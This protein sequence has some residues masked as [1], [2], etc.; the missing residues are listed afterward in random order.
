MSRR[1]GWISLALIASLSMLAQGT[2]SSEI[3]VSGKPWQLLGQGYQLTADSAVDK[4]GIVYFTD[5]QN[6][7]I[8]K[9]DLE[10]RINVWKKGSHGTHGVAFGANGR[11]YGGQHGRKKIVAF[12]RDGKESVIAEGVQ[13]HHLT[14]TSRNVIYFSE[15]PAHKVWMVDAMGRKRVVDDSINW[16]RSVRVSPDQTSLVVDDPPTSSVWKFQ[17]RSD[18]SLSNRRS[19]CRLETRDGASDPDAGGM[20]FDSE[21]F[22]YVATNI[23]VQVCDPLGRVTAI[24]EAPGRE[25]VF[26]VFFGGAALQWLYATDGDKIYRRPVN[27]IGASF[28]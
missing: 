25:G 24:I 8:L 22:L 26:N 17:I 6:N 5:A 23:G 9:V 1:L 2:K 21:G 3:L 10:G 27:R 7:R 13:T 12:S 18:E 16:P 15:A 11:L 14:M 4:D 19:F 28:K 20:A